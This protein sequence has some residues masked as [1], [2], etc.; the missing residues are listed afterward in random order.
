[1]ALLSSMAKLNMHAHQ[2]LGMYCTVLKF[3]I[4]LYHRQETSSHS[5]YNPHVIRGIGG[6]TC[7][8]G[9]PSAASL[10]DRLDLLRS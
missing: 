6:T 9:G 4:G 8:K 2:P 5:V 10:L 1:M 7:G 3:V